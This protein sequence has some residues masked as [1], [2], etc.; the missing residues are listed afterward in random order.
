MIP[1][2]FPAEIEPERL[3]DCNAVLLN[4]VNAVELWASGNDDVRDFDTI[5]LGVLTDCISCSVTEERN[6]E[7]ELTMEYPITGAH[8]SDIEL[9]CIILAKP[10]YS[11][12]PQAFRIYTMTTPIDGVVTIAARHLS[13][14]LS[15]V[16][17]LPFTATS[18]AAACQGLID[19]A[20]IDTRFRVNTTT[21]LVAQRVSSLRH[22]DLIL[23]L[24][25][26]QVIGAGDHAHLMASCEE[27]RIIA[28]TQMGEGQEVVS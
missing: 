22:A 13:Y 15:G 6:G 19:N 7:Y 3:L 8:F 23:M 27:Y 28:E 21:L 9:R 24:D 25:D 26:S 12:V 17:V 16:P 11:D 2:L 1:I 18:A 5:G 10:N 20:A 4:D 14:D